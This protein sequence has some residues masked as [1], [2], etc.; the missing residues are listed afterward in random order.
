MLTFDSLRESNLSVHSS[1]VRFIHSLIFSFV[2]G[3]GVYDGFCLG[4]CD[5]LLEKCKDEFYDTYA[6]ISVQIPICKSDSMLCSKFSDH[7]TTGDAFCNLVGF[8]V[9]QMRTPTLSTEHDCFNGTSSVFVKYDRLDIDFELVYSR[10]YPDINDE[11][12]DEPS[13]H[14]LDWDYVNENGEDVFDAVG[15]T[16]L[17]GDGFV[18]SFY[19][20]LIRPCLKFSRKFYRSYLSGIF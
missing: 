3:S 20:Y 5:L 7:V 8:P 2:Q 16:I 11:E 13:I 17:A 1:T 9:S 4:Y 18:T 12:D 15:N 19:Y 10:D 14:P 6:N